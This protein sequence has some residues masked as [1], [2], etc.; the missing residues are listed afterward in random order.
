MTFEQ[1]EAMVQKTAQYPGRE[2]KSLTYPVL[3][4]CGESGEIA[5]KVKKLLRNRGKQ[6]GTELTA[7]EQ[8]DLMK[9]VGDVLWY[10]A[11]FAWSIG[12]SLEEVAQMNANKILDRLARNVIKSEGDNR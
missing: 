1:Y 9:E 10:T 4:L 6:L 12:S 2:E 11:A 7:E 5:E 8:L 3:G